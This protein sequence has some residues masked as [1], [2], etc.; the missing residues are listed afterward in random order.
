MRVRIRSRGN[1]RARA[2]AGQGCVDRTQTVCAPP[3]GSASQTISWPQAGAVAHYRLC[4]GSC[5]AAVLLGCGAG[6]VHA[7]ATPQRITPGQQI[8]TQHA[9]CTRHARDGG[10]YS[11]AAAVERKDRAEHLKHALLRARDLGIVVHPEHLRRRVDRQ[12][13]YVVQVVVARRI[14]RRCKVR[15]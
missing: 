9:T 2:E 1:Q 4:Q 6:D 12:R 10:R 7:A 5:K 11:P 3:G 13:C 8:R 15:A 14:V